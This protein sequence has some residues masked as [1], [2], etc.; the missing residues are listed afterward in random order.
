LSQKVKL[1]KGYAKQVPALN[2][3]TGR[4]EFITT[5]SEFGITYDTFM[6]YFDLNKDGG[7]KVHRRLSL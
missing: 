7:K 4:Y 1:V 5:L 6:S 3:E 2:D